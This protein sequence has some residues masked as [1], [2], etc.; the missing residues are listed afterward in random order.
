MLLFSL[1]DC[2]LA[3][4][5]LYLATAIVFRK[6]DLQLFETGR[7]DVDIVRDCFVGKPKVDSKGIRVSVVAER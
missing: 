7:E 6:F 1:T 4:A 5:E 3:Y 2:S